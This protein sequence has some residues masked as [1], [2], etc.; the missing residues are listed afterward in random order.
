MKTAAFSLIVSL[1]VLWFVFSSS[2]LS[3]D[4]V[5]VTSKRS[6]LRTSIVETLQ[7][8][9]CKN[10]VDVACV[11][12][13]GKCTRQKDCKAPYTFTAGTCGEGCGCCS[14][15]SSVDVCSVEDDTCSVRIMGECKAEDQCD[16]A[17]GYIFDK[18][19]C[20]SE[21][22]TCGCCYPDIKY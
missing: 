13:L 5:S 19:S 6:N 9:K 20:K 16:T 21:S 7:A 17:N 3:V 1:I 12:A 2:T 15:Q 4:A 11:K 14:M 22:G 18:N 10:I 8:N